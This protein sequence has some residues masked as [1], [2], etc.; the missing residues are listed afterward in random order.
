MYNPDKKPG[1]KGGLVRNT[2]VQILV[3]GDAKVGKSTLINNY[4][5]DSGTQEVEM[6]KES[7]LIRI[8]NANSMIQNPAN[9]D[10]HTNINVT[11]VDVEGSINNVNKQIRDG[12]YTTS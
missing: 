5:S 4:V 2:H 12:Y 10:E 9:P 6:A 3:I 7:E 8:V 11:L 1:R